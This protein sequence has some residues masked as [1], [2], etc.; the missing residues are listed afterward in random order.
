MRPTRIARARLWL[1]SLAIM[2]A[3][4]LALAQRR[5]AAVTEESLKPEA[6]TD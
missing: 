6:L 5:G 3:P 2:L 1:F 4:A